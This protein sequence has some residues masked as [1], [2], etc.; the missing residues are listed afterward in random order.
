MDVPEDVSL[1]QVIHD[2]RE[3]IQPVTAVI[4]QQ[5]KHNREADY[6]RW[7]QRIS[8][9]ARQFPGHCGV[10]VIR[11]EAG[12]CSEYVTI[13]KFDCYAHL[14]GWLDS[15][16]RQRCLEEAKPLIANTS[17]VQILTGFETWFTLPNR[18]R[19]PAPPRYKMAILTTLA[20]FGAVNLLNPLLLPLFSGL[21]RLLSSLIITYLVVLLLTYV[22]MP[23][24]TKLFYRWL[25][26]A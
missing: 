8:A 1:V 25:Y 16:E 9:T 12:I 20:V 5:V 17:T 19:Q 13:L 23:R 26:P 7:T 14:K 4:S 6:E 18:K 3:D 10:T 21:P 24:L 22:V 15:K 2:R 11:P